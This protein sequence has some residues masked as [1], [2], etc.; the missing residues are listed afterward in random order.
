MSAPDYALALDVGGTFTDV[1]MADR[2]GGALWVTK[3]PST[4]AAPADGFFGGADQ[5][6]RLVLAF[7]TFQR[8]DRCPRRRRR[9]P[10]HTACR[11]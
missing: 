7:L 6:A 1:I 5:C 4:P 10:A 3:S 9:R 2:A 8:R 11:P